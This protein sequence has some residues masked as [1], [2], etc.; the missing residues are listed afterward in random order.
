MKYI[1]QTWSQ[2]SV[3]EGFMMAAAL[4]Y[5]TL[6]SIAPLLVI[7][8]AV[9]GFISQSSGLEEEMFNQLSTLLG[10]NQSEELRSMVANAR[11]NESGIAATVISGVTLIIAATA[12]VIQ[13]KNTLN[14]AWNV[15]K[16]PELGFKSLFVDR[17]ISLG[18]L[19][20]LGFVFLVSLGLNAIAMV[21]TNQIQVLLPELGG[22]TFLIISMLIGFLVTYVLFY[23][24]F[25]F[26]PDAKIFNKDLL[27]G[28]LV[29]TI[30]FTIGK[31]AIGFY[32]SSSD[33]GN[34]FGSAGAL[35]SFMIWVYYN[36]VILI[37]GAEFTQVYTLNQNREVHPTDQS[38]KVKRVLKDETAKA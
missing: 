19:L 11:L 38:V 29:T 30:M 24:L 22:T 15:T 14:R 35:A 3:D 28:A 5:Y 18:F 25:R 21:M 26:L 27:V 6:F 32:L 33:I 7:V 13:L 20:G 1:K 36:A 2:F 9:V 12:V 4:S 8:I 34:A 10:A 17:L 16:D 23:L 37:M 31:F